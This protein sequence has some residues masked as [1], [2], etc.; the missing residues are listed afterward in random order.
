MDEP[1]KIVLLSGGHDSTGLLFKLLEEQGSENLFAHFINM[2]DPEGRHVCE[3]RAVSMIVSYIRLNY[4]PALRLTTSSFQFNN[5]TFFMP[6]MPIIAFHA[7]LAT[8]EVID[9]VWR[10]R[11]IRPVEVYTGGHRDD[12]A[13]HGPQQLKE[14]YDQ[15]QIIFNSFF[16]V[17]PDDCP[18][19]VLKYPAGDKSKSDLV[20]YIP[21]NVR[22]HVWSCRSPQGN[23]TIKIQCGSCFPCQQLAKIYRGEI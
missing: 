17:Y 3:A 18:R 10:S 23:D 14:R 15:L 5:T 7:A 6:D 1:Y 20:S 21:E 13:E 9:D 11:G 12:P 16:Y 19:P 4:E 22:P 8:R 2:N